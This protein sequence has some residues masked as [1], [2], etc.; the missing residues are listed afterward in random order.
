MENFSITYIFTS[1]DFSWLQNGQLNWVSSGW[2]AF[3][4]GGGL[5]FAFRRA[6]L[7][8]SFFFFALC[9]Y[10]NWNLSRVC[11]Q[12]YG[13]IVEYLMKFLILRRNSIE[14]SKKKIC[15]TKNYWIL[16]EYLH[17]SIKYVIYILHT[18]ECF[19][20]CDCNFL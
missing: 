12:T 2:I 19:N 18:N 10:L 13:F 1:H 3:R 7:V 11:N 9:W 20:F 8:N 17:R 5:F 14:N 4:F 15:F 6:I 16:C